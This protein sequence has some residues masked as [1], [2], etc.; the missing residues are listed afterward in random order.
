M[1]TTPTTQNRK[2]NR[3]V[4][5]AAAAVIAVAV[6]AGAVYW[7]Q[8]HN[9]LSQASA[10]DCRLA[11]S[12]ITEGAEIS[13]AP[14]SEA[15]KWWRAA[16]DERRAKMKDG[17][18]GAKISQYEGWALATAKESSETPSAKD[19]KNLQ[20]EAQGHCADSGVTLSMPPLG[21]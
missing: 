16:G 17:Y 15:E 18:L 5:S 21:S 14:A 11:Q 12:I 6:A 4:I 7:W 13:T 8:D 10:E 3:L 9:K 1:T 2:R 20:E 19:V